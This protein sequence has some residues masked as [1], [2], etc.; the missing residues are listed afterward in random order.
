MNQIKSSSATNH[1]SNE[2]KPMNMSASEIVEGMYSLWPK[3]TPAQA[4]KEVPVSTAAKGDDD[5]MS[6]PAKP[7]AKSTKP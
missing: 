1:S 7:A 3:A 6:T 4:K 5:I 2:S